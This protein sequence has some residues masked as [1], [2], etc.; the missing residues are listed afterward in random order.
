M[1]FQGGVS[2]AVEAAVRDGSF[3]GMLAAIL[4]HAEAVHAPPLHEMLLSFRP[5]PVVASCCLPFA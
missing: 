4:G 1:W 2:G 5:P 3:S